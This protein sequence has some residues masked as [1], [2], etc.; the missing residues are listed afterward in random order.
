MLYQIDILEGN[1]WL[2]YW[3]SEDINEIDKELF[4]LTNVGMRSRVLLDTVLLCWLDGTEY[5]YWYWKNKYVRK[6]GLAF[7]YVKSY[8]NHEKKKIKKIDEGVNNGK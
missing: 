3:E 7:D 2:Y 1:E 5:Q 4:H 8:H 6:R